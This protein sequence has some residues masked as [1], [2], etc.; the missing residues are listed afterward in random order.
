MDPKVAIC[1]ALLESAQRKL[2]IRYADTS[3]ARNTGHIKKPEG[4]GMRNG[5]KGIPLD[6]LDAPGTHNMRAFGVEF[7]TIAPNLRVPRL[8]MQRPRGARPPRPPVADM[9]DV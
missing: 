8:E 9:Q 1:F 2:A 4:F 7:D 6:R 5:V 3:L